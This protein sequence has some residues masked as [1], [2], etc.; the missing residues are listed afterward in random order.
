M[1]TRQQVRQEVM[2]QVQSFA[3]VKKL[4]RISLSQVLHQRQGACAAI[5]LSTVSYTHFHTP[6]SSSPRVTVFDDALF[7]KK[8]YG[9]MEIQHI[10]PFC[11][12]ESQSERESAEEKRA[13]EEA[14]R[15]TLWLEKG[16]FAALE[17][18]YLERLV[19]SIESKGKM[20]EL[21][22][23]KFSYPDA[24]SCSLTLG[25]EMGEGS[26]AGASSSTT[27]ETTYSLNDICNSAVSVVRMRAS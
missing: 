24:T 7:A 15:C 16:V 18:Q 23:W 13:R 5:S 17:K 11:E 14:L 8:A 9:S 3:M 25:S 12:D 20:V 4:V 21:Y 26:R 1:T 2:T 19:F 27:A 22:S 10:W 6:P